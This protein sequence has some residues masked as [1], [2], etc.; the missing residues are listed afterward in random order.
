MTTPPDKFFDVRITSRVDFADDLWKIRVVP[1]HAFHF[2]PGQY[3]TLGVDNGAGLVERAY[4]IVSSPYEDEIEFFFELVPQGA[5]TP[6]LY[7]LVPETRLQP[8]K[9]PRAGSRS[10][11]PVATRTISFCPR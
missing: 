2:T 6:L 5:L 3:A 11:R 8:E 7:R 4:S 1:S 10:T 9:W